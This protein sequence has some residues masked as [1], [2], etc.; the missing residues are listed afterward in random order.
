MAWA[1]ARPRPEC[2]PKFSPSG[3]TE[4]KR[5]KIASR[6][7]GGTPGPSS[8]T[9]IR[10]SSPTRAAAIST[11]PPGGEKLTALSMMALMA[12][13]S[14]SGLR[15]ERREL[16]ERRWLPAG[17][18]P[19][20][21][22]ADRTTL[23]SVCYLRAQAALAHPDTLAKV[24]EQL[25]QS[26]A[27]RARVQAQLATA[28]PQFK[29]ELVREAQARAQT[30]PIFAR[31]LGSVAEDLR[32]VSTQVGGSDQ[33]ATRAAQPALRA[34]RCTIFGEEA[35]LGYCIVAIAIFIILLGLGK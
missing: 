34:V 7:S 27:F 30:D 33:A 32:E 1:M 26:A 13:A 22:E 16:G 31:Q 14:R 5:L 3:L 19:G 2:R 9:R 4:W 25:Q 24:R 29:R 35:P 20:T 28:G 23:I 18:A 10:T 21:P 8:S 11:K 6:A 12:R 15:R 17:L